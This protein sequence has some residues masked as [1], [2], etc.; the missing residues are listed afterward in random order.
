MESIVTIMKRGLSCKILIVDI[1][2]TL[3]LLWDRHSRVRMEVGFITTYAISAYHHWHFEF[4]SRSRRSVQQYVIKLV[5]GFLKVLR[6]PPPIKLTNQDITEILLKVVLNTI[7]QTNKHAYIVN[8]NIRVNIIKYNVFS[9]IYVSDH[10][11][12]WTVVAMLIYYFNTVPT[13]L[14]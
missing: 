10:Y 4:K 5:G 14:D 13:I 1:V 2:N 9:N 3:L 7:K 12:Y 11:E 6:F 8:D